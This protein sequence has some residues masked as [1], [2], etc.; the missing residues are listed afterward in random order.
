MCYSCFLKKI[1]AVTASPSLKEWDIF[2]VVVF[3]FAILFRNLKE[4]IIPGYILNFV[5][6]NF[7]SESGINYLLKDQNEK[8][9][10]Q[11]N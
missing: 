2:N 6:Q 9:Y 7:V 11:C 8:N 3:Y 10:R 5:S 1:D 4:F